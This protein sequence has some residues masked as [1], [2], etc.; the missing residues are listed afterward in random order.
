M[1]AIPL[2]IV[3]GGPIS[4][5]I[6]SLPGLDGA[7]GL[8]N[9]QW[10]FVLEGLPALFAGLAVYRLLPDRP[11]AASWL[12][13]DEAHALSELVATENTGAVAEHARLTEGLFSLPTLLLSFAYFGA[14]L[15]GFGIIFWTPQIVKG[16]G[17]SNVETGFVAAIPYAFAVAA[18]IVLGRI[19]DRSG[20]R[21]ALVAGPLLVGA[22]GLVVAGASSDL[23]LSIV[24]LTLAACGIYG[25][26]PSFWTL[27][28]T[29]LTGSARAAAFAI[30]NSIGALGGFVGP[31]V[32]AWVKEMRGE[33]GLGLMVLGAGAACSAALVL[34]LARLRPAPTR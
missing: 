12:S 20:K 11:G 4:G 21:I 8:K 9:W 19:G 33:F 7:G 24:A 10:M 14:L 22:L 16:F 2:S 29:Y 5:L 25:M 26:L 15:G 23:R 30:V 34:L 3:I 13:P 1:L 27:P 17:L 18:M 31:Y 28:P 6:L 32:I